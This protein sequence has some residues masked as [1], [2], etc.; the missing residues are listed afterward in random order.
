MIAK[1]AIIKRM[2]RTATPFDYEVP[3]GL[4][5][6]VGSFV[7]V[8]LR[9]GS[10]TGLVVEMVDSTELE[11][12]KCVNEVLDLP[13][14]RESDVEFYKALARRTYQS[15]SSI[16]YAAIPAKPKRNVAV[17]RSEI[18]PI[19][20]SIASNQVPR[21]QRTVK[22]VL[23][24]DSS[25]LVAPSDRFQLAVLLGLLKKSSDPLLVIC[26]DIETMRAV[27]GV[28]RSV[29][30]EVLV[31]GGKMSKTEAYEGWL[32]IREGRSR[33][34]VSTRVGALVPPSEDTRVV[35]VRS[36]EDDH[37]QWDQNPHY[38]TRWCVSEMSRLCGNRALSMCVM[39][40]VEDGELTAD[41]WSVPPYKIVKL[42]DARKRSD[43]FLVSDE[44]LE[45]IREAEAERPVYIFY[46]RIDSDDRFGTL[47]VANVIRD[48]V[49]GVKV[50]TAASGDKL[51]T[52]GVIVAT[53]TLMYRLP[54]LLKLGAVIVLNAEQSFVAKGF[55]S[56]E[57]AARE[58][59]RLASW[60][61][62]SSAPM[63]IQTREPDSI[64]RALGPTE[65]LRKHE[66]E[67]R[68]ILKYPPVADIH[69]ARAKDDTELI[70]SYKEQHT[71]V[72]GGQKE[73]V[74]RREPG[75]VVDE[76]LTWPQSCDIFVN[77]DSM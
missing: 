30:D 74:V 31:Y 59:R 4:T 16:L 18:E 57:R 9:G 6:Q 63:V 5:V 55:R 68:M 47:Q 65:T 56:G 3:E 25:S 44:V 40:R 52:E 50:S 42:D 64:K 37:A 46:N 38:D 61:A 58:L 69:V 28:A 8:P 53:R 66:I 70:D 20:L 2:P 10:A 17:K 27:A 14:L 23:E 36:G 13:A 62:E 32:D 12:V 60:A 39:P 71:N 41:L 1:V 33:I 73:A 45:V 67:M 54:L 77:P 22:E 51:P 48:A 7:D 72:T 21:L 35:L 11:K 43:H 26:P 29:V 15:I 75:A 76:W 19:R 24:T 34:V 49:P